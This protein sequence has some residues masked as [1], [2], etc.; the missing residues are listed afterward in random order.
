MTKADP[1]KLLLAKMKA[2]PMHEIA[3]TLGAA[4]Q[5]PVASSIAQQVESALFDSW[6]PQSVDDIFKLLKLDS[7]GRP[8][9]NYDGLSVWI[10]YVT[11]VKGK[12]ADEQMYK[13]LR[14]TYGDDELAMILAGSKQFTFADVAQKLENLQQKVWL[15][16]G[17]SAKAVFT[18]LKLNT[19]GDK[20]FISPALSSWIDYVTKLSPKNADQMMMSALKS[21]YK[22]DVLA[23]MILAAEKSDETKAVA[24]KLGQA[25]VT[26]WLRRD[27]SADEVF[28][29][30]KL[31]VEVDDLL[32]HPLLST[33]VAYVEKIN[34]NPY[35][36]LLKKMK[37][38]KLN[39]W[40]TDD[41]SIVSL[42]DEGEGWYK[43]RR[44]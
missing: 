9:F 38:S 31:D 36:I 10:S 42:G 6:V 11:K 34:E 13:I 3:T 4:K 30:L 2:R 44:Q 21:S 40:S 32:T 12:Q 19:Q 43:C 17:K 35:A 18:A 27:K 5:D 1:Y 33:W 8:F 16:D 26:D 23:K 37:S 24:E 20:L 39:N 22:D 14:A 41:Q 7:I 28:T 15:I 25:Q 29:L